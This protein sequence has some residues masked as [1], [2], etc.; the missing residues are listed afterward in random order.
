M[1]AQPHR[2][3]P[4][5]PRRDEAIY[6]AVLTLVAEVGVDR[7]SLDA[8]AQRAGVSKPTIYRRCPHGK[9]QLVSAAVA[10]RSESKPAAPNTGTLRGDL[11]AMVRRLSADI[12][13]NAHLAAGLTS[14]LRTDPELAAIFREHVIEAERARWRQVLERAAARGEL[15]ST[16]TPLF[17]DVGPSF[18]HSRMTV[19]E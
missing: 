1:I 7:M 8:V 5:D 9:A 6:E 3:R 2:G 17:A 16:V 4:R 11:L 10:F 19:G 12:T 18:I 13:E 15:R 14:R